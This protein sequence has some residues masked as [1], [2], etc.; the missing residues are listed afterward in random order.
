MIAFLGMPEQRGVTASR[1]PL[2]NSRHANREA[3]LAFSVGDL[4][5]G[6]AACD[7]C[8]RNR[9]AFVGCVVVSGFF[10]GACANCHHGGEASK[11]S[12]RSG[13]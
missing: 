6:T 3:A 8:Q 9:G 2:L 5:T 11:C 7:R 1:D 12:F 4:R 13:K 10:K